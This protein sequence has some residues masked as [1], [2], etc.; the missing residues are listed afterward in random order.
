MA[1]YEPESFQIPFQESRGASGAKL[2]VDS[3]KAVAANTFREP[4]VRTGIYRRRRRDA[5]METCVENG[6]LRDVSEQFLDD[7]NNFQFASIMERRERRHACNSRLHGG[8]DLKPFFVFPAPVDDT[9]PHHIDVLR[10]TWKGGITP[11]KR[12]E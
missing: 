8:S 10:V 4:F 9:R 11:P 12:G 6:Y 5:A 3:M 2:M 7:I 1:G